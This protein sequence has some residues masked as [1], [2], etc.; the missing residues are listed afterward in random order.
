ME[1]AAAFSQSFPYA[2]PAIPSPR[3]PYWHLWV[4]GKR[5]SHHKLCA[6]SHAGFRSGAHMKGIQSSDCD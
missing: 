4:E 6:L 1:T 5:V 3:I 2:R